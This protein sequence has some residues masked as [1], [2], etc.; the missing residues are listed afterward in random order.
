M[1][2]DLLRLRPLSQQPLQRLASVLRGQS[3]VRLLASL[4]SRRS[5]TTPTSTSPTHDDDAR[6]A[7]HDARHTMYLLHYTTHHL[8]FTAHDV[9]PPL[10]NEPP[11]LDDARR[12]PPTHNASPLLDDARRSFCFPRH[13]LSTTS[14]TTDGSC[15]FLRLRCRSARPSACQQRSFFCGS[16]ARAAPWPSWR[17][18][19][20]ARSYEPWATTFSTS[21]L[22]LS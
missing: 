21:S 2:V 14:P 10:L 6:R 1:Y 18:L 8:H 20:T 3:T 11:P 5:F 19:E 22:K 7:T 17:F 4:N 13:A 15:S 9:P 16:R 12:T